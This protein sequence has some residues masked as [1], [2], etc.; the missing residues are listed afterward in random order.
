M[1]PEGPLPDTSSDDVR[2]MLPGAA[3][4]QVRTGVPVVPVALIGTHGE[5]P[6]D[7]PLPRS[8]IDMVFGEPFTPQVPG[9]PMARSTIMEVAEVIR[10]RLTDHVDEAWRRSGRTGEDFSM[11]P[12]E[13]GVS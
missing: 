4:V 12:G 10:Q 2:P 11:P 3:Y 7:P 1:F 9:D 5:R 8:Q 6:S 13:N